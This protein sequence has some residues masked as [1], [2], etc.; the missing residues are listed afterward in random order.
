MLIY[1]TCHLGCNPPALT[2]RDITANLNKL[3]YMRYTFKFLPVAAKYLTTPYGA[4]STVAG[5]VKGNADNISVIV[6]FS[7]TGKYMGIMMLKLKN[8][9]LR[10]GLRIAHIISGIMQAAV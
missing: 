3:R 5:S 2:S 10:A 8:L 6:I 1:I 7:H 9:H 4:V